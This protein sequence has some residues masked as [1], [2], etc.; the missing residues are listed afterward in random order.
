MSFISSPQ[1]PKIKDLVALRDSKKRRELGVFVVEGTR[2]ITR[3]LDSGYVCRTLYIEDN[4]LRG[5]GQD[6][7]RR[8]PESNRFGVSKEAF[9]KAAVREGSDG[10]L[11][12]MEIKISTF[13]DIKATQ[14]P[15]FL[16]VVEGIEKPGNFGAL[17]RSAD[18][19]GVDAIVVLDPK[20]DL[21]NPN[22]VRASVGALFTRP[23]ITA[24]HE[25]FF[26]FCK[27]KNIKIIAAS[28]H[29]KNYHY[30]A[31]LKPALALVLGSEAWGLSG[32]WQ[33][34][35][36]DLVKI[37]MNGLADSLNVSVAG[38]VIMYEILRQRS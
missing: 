8:I 18:G 28:P 29:A 35:N 38:A 36:S 2:E 13:A 11:A 9:A 25:E 10:V 4:L 34:Q 22:A 3:A 21:F 26:E 20:A 30:Q 1:N 24:T 17:A 37:P 23:L 16:L 33:T 14:K 6:L 32:A 7:V 19:V 31:D 27:A 5:E 15:L 12:V